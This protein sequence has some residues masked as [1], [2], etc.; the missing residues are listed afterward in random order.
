M[1]KGHLRIQVTTDASSLLVLQE[2]QE[3]KVVARNKLPQV[4]M[5]VRIWGIRAIDHVLLWHS[6]VGGNCQHPS[7]QLNE[8]GEQQAVVVHTN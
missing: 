4:V 1:S 2:T 7:N 3:V 6:F 5:E 8:R